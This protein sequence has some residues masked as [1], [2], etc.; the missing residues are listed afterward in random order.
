MQLTQPLGSRP[1]ATIHAGA[2]L[3]FVGLVSGVVGGAAWAWLRPP[4]VAVVSDGAFVIDTAAT[5]QNAQFAG[6]GWL[7]VVLLVVG[8]IV[9]L[10]GR[11]HRGGGQLAWFI[12]Q[13]VVSALAGF[14]VWTVGGVV[15]DWLISMPE[16]AEG[17]QDGQR[18]NVVPRVAP[19]VVLCL[20]PFVTGIAAWW[21]LVL[22]SVDTPEIV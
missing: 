13:L 20:A 9:G 22:D 6:L 21:R 5:A 16:H 18:I 10:A 17:F 8:L 7:A 3:L 14:V 15:T 11:S 4:I 2:G 19:S 12:W 1:R